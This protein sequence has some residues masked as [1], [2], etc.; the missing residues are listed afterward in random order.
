MK[1]KLLFFLLFV[2]LSVWS[3]NT[4]K[5]ITLLNSETNLPVE[6]ATI[7]IV[8]TKQSFLSNSDGVVTFVINGNS[9]IQITHSSFVSV[10]VRAT[11]LKEMNT[12]VYLKSTVNDLDEII[13]TKKHPQKILKE[14]VENSIHKLSVPARLKVYSREFFK[15]NGKYTYYNDG[16]M[17]FQLR[18]N[19]SNFKTDILVEQ[20]RSFGLISDEIGADALGYNLNDIMQNYYNFKYLNPVLISSGRKEYDFIIK[21]YKANDEYN[22]MLI[23]PLENVDE[24]RD[25]IRIVYDHKRKIIIEI[26][27]FV[28]PTTIARVKDKSAVGSKNIYK[29]IFKNIYKYENSNYYLVSSKEEIGFER[30]DK[31]KKTDIEVRNY[32]VTTNFNSRNFTYKDSDVFKD[33]TLYNKSNVILS[34][35]WNISGLTATEDEKEIIVNLQDR[36]P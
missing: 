15:L 25:D 5:T 26:S 22:V 8:K 30:I 24:L 28:S 19:S 34:D 4:E 29:S 10:T 23:T 17:N 1:V 18:G 20:N 6:D 16:L 9:N 11:T 2:S 31:D 33:K 3:Q 35:Y 32:F 12:V 27:S 14:I 7:F 13:V 21:G 36:E